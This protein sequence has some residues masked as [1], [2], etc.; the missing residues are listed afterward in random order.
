MVYKINVSS[1]IM[2]KLIKLP[3]DVQKRFDLLYETLERC[4]PAGAHQWRNYSKLS[5]DEYHCHLTYSYVAIWQH[6]KGTITIEVKYVGSR[7]D[8]PYA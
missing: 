6:E 4:G 2:R 5:K 3:K 7:E 1:K 8:A